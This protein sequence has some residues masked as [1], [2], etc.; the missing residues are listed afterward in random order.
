MRDLL[1]HYKSR[2][3]F[4]NSS[5]S[6]TTVQRLQGSCLR[7][8]VQSNTTRKLGDK[9]CCWNLTHTESLNLKTRNQIDSSK[10]SVIL[11]TGMKL[12]RCRN[13]P[14]KHPPKQGKTPPVLVVYKLSVRASSTGSFAPGVDFTHRVHHSDG[15]WQDEHSKPGF[16]T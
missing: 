10:A 11:L 12:W 15:Y 6:Q 8:T 7:K 5:D 13:L 9:A 2:Q 14:G 1:C 16:F 3:Q 4:N